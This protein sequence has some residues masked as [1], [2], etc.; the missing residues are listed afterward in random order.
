[1]GGVPLGRRYRTF[2]AFPRC[3]WHPS[4]CCFPTEKLLIMTRQT[5]SLHLYL[6]FCLYLYLYWLNEHFSFADKNACRCWYPLWLCLYKSCHENDW[7]V[8][9]GQRIHW[10]IIIHNNMYARKKSFFYRRFSV[11]TDD[12][13]GRL[14]HF[15]KKTICFARTFAQECLAEV[16]IAFAT[17]THPW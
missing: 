3:Y 4:G 16:T 13:R 11:S 15:H 14:N 17:D 5:L 9:V 12:L 10:C 8:G 7:G 6:Y 2:K 1:M